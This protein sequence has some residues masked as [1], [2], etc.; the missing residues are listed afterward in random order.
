MAAIDL[1]ALGLKI[2]AI[3]E[4]EVKKRRIKATIK[5]G[6]LTIISTRLI[7]KSFKGKTF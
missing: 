1:E 2:G 7:S 3:G 4:I 6:H 5:K